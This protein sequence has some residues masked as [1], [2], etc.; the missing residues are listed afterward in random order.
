M[1]RSRPPSSRWWCT[2]PLAARKFQ[3][4]Q[5]YRLQNFERCAAEVDG[6]RLTMEGLALTGAWVDRERGLLSL[7][8]LEMGALARACAPRSSPASRWW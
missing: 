4:G 5:F 7:I 2:R 6:T 1:P 8:V 3:P